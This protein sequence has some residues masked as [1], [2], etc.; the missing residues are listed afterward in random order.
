[1]VSLGTVLAMVRP[2]E[3]PALVHARLAHHMH[4]AFLAGQDRFFGV[5]RYG[6]AAT[7]GGIGD[8]HFG[9]GQSA[10]DLFDRENV[11]FERERRDLRL[12]FRCWPMSHASGT[13]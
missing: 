10:W 7:A 4:L 8:Q 6:A 12:F 3:L 11:H 5:V 9:T 1:M 13:C 2:F